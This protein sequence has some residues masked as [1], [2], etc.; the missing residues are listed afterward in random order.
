MDLHGVTQYLFDRLKDVRPVTVQVGDETYAVSANGTLGA[1]VRALAPQFEAPCFE[2][3]T[4]SGL[5]ALVAAHVDRY[6][7]TEG[8][9]VV[10]HIADV[11][12][13]NL[14]SAAADPFGRRHIYA[15]ASHTEETPFRFGEYYKSPEEFLIAFR[16]SFYFDEQAVK[17]QQ[18]C[19]T[20]GAGEAVAV[21]DDGLSQEVV[22]K[23]GTVTKSS[24]TLPAD[25]VPLI[26]W[27]TFREV[28][29]VQSRFL[30]RLRGVRD[31]LPQ[32]A[33]FAIDQL[34][35]LDTINAIAHWLESNIPGVP[36]IR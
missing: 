15:S 32:I 18:L 10:L 19:S 11:Q 35:R 1:P 3:A 23:T 27:R 4:L 17:V 6:D 25:G 7:L 29:P 5:S 28:S 26:P 13:V 12:T 33:L 8:N 30:L 14:V 16:A 36:V 34:W 9:G 20:L 2:V 24:V 31:G 22:V 21:T